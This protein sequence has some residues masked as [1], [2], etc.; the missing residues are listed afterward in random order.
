[1]NQ[2]GP[3]CAGR[4]GDGV[5]QGPNHSGRVL[6]S[7]QPQGPDLEMGEQPD[8]S[9]CFK[10][11]KVGQKPGSETPRTSSLVLTRRINYHPAW[12]GSSCSAKARVHPPALPHHS[13]GPVRLHRPEILELDKVDVKPFVDQGFAPERQ[14]DCPRP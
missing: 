3:K 12:Q 8:H 14:S 10:K 6:V 13:Q 4:H 9:S 5:S 2:L 1:M 7:P 11:P